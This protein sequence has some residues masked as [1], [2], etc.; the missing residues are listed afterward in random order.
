M[1]TVFGALVQLDVNADNVREKSSGEF[2]GFQHP[3]ECPEP[4]LFG[5]AAYTI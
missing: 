4:L 3:S 2:F 5:Y 1:I